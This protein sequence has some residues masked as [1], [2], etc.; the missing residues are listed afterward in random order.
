MREGEP[1]LTR[2]LCATSNSVIVDQHCG[3]GTAGKLRPTTYQT[4]TLIKLSANFTVDGLPTRKI[5]SKPL[6]F[7]IVRARARFLQQVPSYKLEIS[8]KIPASRLFFGFE[9]LT[10]GAAHKFL[11]WLLSTDAA[12]LHSS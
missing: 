2:D 11:G 7:F 4:K 3:S 12:R 5:I 1:A 8:C 9:Y 10:K 6:F